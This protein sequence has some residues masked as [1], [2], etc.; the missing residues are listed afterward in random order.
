M[1]DDEEVINVEPARA[2]QALS[3]VYI[4]QPDDESFKLTLEKPTKI[5]EVT[6]VVEGVS[7]VEV[8]IGEEYKQV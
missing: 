8:K 1:L 7:S 3:D 2:E 4:A 6:L 5:S